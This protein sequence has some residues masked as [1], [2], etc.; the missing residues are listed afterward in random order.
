MEADPKPVVRIG[1]IRPVFEM[2]AG[3]LGDEKNNSPASQLFR[4]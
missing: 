2:A 1:V 3:W 4:S